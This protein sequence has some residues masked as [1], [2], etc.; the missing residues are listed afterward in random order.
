MWKLGNYYVQLQLN[1]KFHVELGQGS[2][3]FH[4]EILA[5]HEKNIK[6][7]SIHKFRENSTWINSTAE[8]TEFSR[9]EINTQ[10][11]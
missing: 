4:I 9:N 8:I 2:L 1:R 10:Y 5:F 6:L 11:L 3:S 7:L